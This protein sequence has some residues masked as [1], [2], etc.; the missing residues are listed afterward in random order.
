MCGGRGEEEEIALFK[1]VVCQVKLTTVLNSEG[2]VLGGTVGRG[3]IAWFKAACMPK[4]SQLLYLSQSM[5]GETSH[6]YELWNDNGGLT[7]SC[8]NPSYNQS[9]F[10]TKHE[11]VE[12]AMINTKIHP[13]LSGNFTLPIAA[14]IIWNIKTISWKLDSLINILYLKILDTVQ[15]PS[16][17]REVL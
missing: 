3:Q 10:C 15:Y 1:P 6:K 16:L 11:W 9:R 17:W 5:Y 12:T 2:V 14:R 4:P 8:F 13:S 7:H